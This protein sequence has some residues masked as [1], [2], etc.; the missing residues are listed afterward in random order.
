MEIQLCGNLYSY[1]RIQRF[2]VQYS[3]FEK[4]RPRDG[5]VDK[6]IGFFKTCVELTLYM[7]F[8]GGINMT[9]GRKE[10][11]QCKLEIIDLNAVVPSNHILRQIHEKIDLSFIYNKIVMHYSKLGRNSLDPVLLFKI[12]DHIV[13]LCMEKGLVPVEVIVTDSTHIKASASV[14]K[15]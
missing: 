6:L 4:K 7:F 5:A 2:Y 11:Y 10:E 14:S 1:F 13:K 15:D 9:M 12:F 8:I 3:W